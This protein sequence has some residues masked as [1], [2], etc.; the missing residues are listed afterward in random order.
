MDDYI[1]KQPWT[2][3]LLETG[4]KGAPPAHLAAAEFPHP[5]TLSTRTVET[6]ALVTAGT[7]IVTV[8]SRTGSRQ[9]D[10]QT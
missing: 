6:T 10:R 4:S 7:G 8:T 5:A 3:M 2:G 9:V 1:D